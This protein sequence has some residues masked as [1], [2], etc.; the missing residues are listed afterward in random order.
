MGGSNNKRIDNVPPGPELQ[1]LTC[2]GSLFL[3]QQENELAPGGLCHTTPST[4]ERIY[5]VCQCDWTSD[6][7]KIHENYDIGQLYF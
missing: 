6:K 4:A 3:E 7:T 2:F 5:T 1:H